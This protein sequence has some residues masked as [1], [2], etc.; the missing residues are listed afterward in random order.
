M[1]SSIHI[2]KAK[3]K[4]IASGDG[5]GDGGTGTILIDQGGFVISES[6]GE[7]LDLGDQWN[8]PINGRVAAKGDFT[9]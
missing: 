9:L 7:G 4:D 1:A 8:I 3:S 2:T 5:I 6:N